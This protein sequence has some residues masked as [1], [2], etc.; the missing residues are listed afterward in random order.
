M[1]TVT[2][3][4]NSINARQEDENLNQLE[5]WHQAGSIEITRTSILDSE[6]SRDLGPLGDKRRRKASQLQ[7]A[8][9]AFTVGM[10]ALRNG[11][12]LRGVDAYGWVD[13]IAAIIFPN[14]AFQEL[15][16]RPRNDVL[17]LAI[18]KAAN[19]DY[20]VTLD[21]KDILAHQ[22]QLEDECDIH[23]LS[24]EEAVG[25]ISRALNEAGSA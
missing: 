6:L 5:A 10:S 21:R 17:H 2:I 13:Q 14:R 18:H 1:V 12:V 8:S 4:T 23:A 22:Q 11:D 3:D 9:P 7:E 20:L 16:P 15:A 25:V 19:W 24:P